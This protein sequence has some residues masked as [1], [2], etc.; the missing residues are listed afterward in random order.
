[1]G[2]NNWPGSYKR[3]GAWSMIDNMIFHWVFCFWVLRN[4]VS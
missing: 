1:M 3:W 4:L 2:P